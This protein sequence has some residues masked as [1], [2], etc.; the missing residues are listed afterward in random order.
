M[1]NNGLIAVNCT[2]IAIKYVVTILLSP[3]VT[4]VGCP[5]SEVSLFYSLGPIRKMYNI[6]SEHERLGEIN[7]LFLEQCPLPKFAPL[8]KN[9]NY[10]NKGNYLA[11][12]VFLVQPQLTRAQHDQAIKFITAL[13]LVN[14]GYTLHHSVGS[15]NDDIQNHT[16]STL[17][18]GWL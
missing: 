3:N 15:K 4:Y 2:K 1:V 8:F 11:L 12:S 10:E 18:L 14:L 17:L 5:A 6:A 7:Q 13:E 16:S 9:F